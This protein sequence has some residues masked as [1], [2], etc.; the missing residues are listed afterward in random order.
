MKPNTWVG[1][2]LIVLGVWVFVYQ[3]INYTH[4]KTILDVGSVRIATETQ[5][6]FL[7][8]PILGG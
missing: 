2:L 3:G 1:R 7:L 4:K 6:R 5:E 8:S